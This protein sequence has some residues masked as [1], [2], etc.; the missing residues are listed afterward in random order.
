L[1]RVDGERKGKKHIAWGAADRLRARLA[2]E[3]PGAT[4]G[5]PRR[6][7]GMLGDRALYTPKK[8]TGEYGE[9]G[10]RKGVGTKRGGWSDIG[11]GDGRGSRAY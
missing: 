11:R 7:A 5:F 10:W 3:K 1:K 4:K 8:V 6:T 9:G 2:I